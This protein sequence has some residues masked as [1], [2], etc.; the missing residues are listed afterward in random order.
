MQ[1]LAATGK[2]G[3]PPIVAIL[4]RTRQMYAENGQRPQL[5]TDI[6]RESSTRTERRF[7]KI[8]NH[9]LLD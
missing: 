3:T 5:S 8:R 6:K 1:T 2:A 9:I 4:G 7:G